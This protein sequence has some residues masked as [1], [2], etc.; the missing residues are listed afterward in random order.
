[1]LIH[2]FS[3]L[4]SMASVCWPYT[5]YVIMIIMYDAGGQWVVQYR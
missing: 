5:Y 3:L 1:M 2:I 4:I